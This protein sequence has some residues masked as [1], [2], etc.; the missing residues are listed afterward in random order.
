M[1]KFYGISFVALTQNTYECLRRTNKQKYRDNYR[2]IIR[3]LRLRM[4]D[5]IPTYSLKLV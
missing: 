1:K 4:R 5:K 3:R 2:L